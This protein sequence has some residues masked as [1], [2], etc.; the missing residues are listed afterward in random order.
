MCTGERRGGGVVC[1]GREGDVPLPCEQAECRVEADPAGTRE[2]RLGPGM[3]FGALIPLERLAPGSFDEVSGYEASAETEV[4]QSGDQQPSA[5]TA[6]PGIRSSV[7]SGSWTP[8]S[9]RIS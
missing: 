3:E 9:S 7:T 4:A 1:A 6:G 2:V 8:D 5:V